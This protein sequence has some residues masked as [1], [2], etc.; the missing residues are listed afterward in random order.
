M[1]ETLG[2]AWALVAIAFFAEAFRLRSLPHALVALG[3]LT[4]ALWTRMGSLLTL[5]LLALWVA[6][7]CAHSWRN[8]TKLF[9]AACAVIM[10]VIAANPCSPY[11]MATPTF[12]L[13]EILLIPCAGCPTGQ[14]GTAVITV[15]KS[16]Y[17]L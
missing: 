17:L 16:N 13:A 12:R 7:A 4:F 8:R 9:L 6:F 1:T 11:C 15:I 10:L 2:L 5:P 3:A 14:A